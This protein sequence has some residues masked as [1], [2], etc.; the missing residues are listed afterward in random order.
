[1]DKIEL[2]LENYGGNIKVGYETIVH[3]SV[4]YNILSILFFVFLLFFMVSGILFTAINMGEDNFNSVNFDKNFK[5]YDLR[6][7]ER[8]MVLLNIIIPIS[9]LVITLIMYIVGNVYCKDYI[10][11]KSI[12]G[13]R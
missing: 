13:G 11:I 1:M 3:Q 2:F 4:V 7:R 8:L 9:C 6:K 12:L 10:L 5:F